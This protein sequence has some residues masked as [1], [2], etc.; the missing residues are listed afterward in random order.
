M[1]APVAEAVIVLIGAPA[2]GKSTLRRRLAGENGSALAVL[3]PDD[4]R[5]EL[6]ARDIAAGLEP[7]ALQDYSFAAIRRCEERANELVASGRGYLADATHLRRRER[8]AHVR[9]AHAAGLPAVAMLLPDLPLAV[10][11]AR[12]A[13][14]LPELRVPDA[15]LGRH[16]HRRSLLSSVLLI[17]EGFDE[18]VEVPPHDA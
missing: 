4:E 2:S 5:A 8:V 17:D 1:T 14:R 12:N 3:S 9:R 10:L 13:R 11:T 16:A 6:R 7:R 18:I 15:V